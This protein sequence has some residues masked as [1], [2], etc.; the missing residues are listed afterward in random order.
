[1][2][3]IQKNWLISDAFKRVYTLEEYVRSK[4]V[5]TFEGP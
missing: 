4:N 2:E 3:S 1:M 5:Y